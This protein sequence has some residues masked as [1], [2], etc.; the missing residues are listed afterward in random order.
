MKNILKMFMNW[1][2]II[3]ILVVI[4]LSY[5]FIP[6]IAN[7]WWL[8]LLLICPISMIFIM[9]NMDGHNHNQNNSKK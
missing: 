7:Y 9:P 5:V 3:G 4:G 8:L 1:Q 6:N 2:F